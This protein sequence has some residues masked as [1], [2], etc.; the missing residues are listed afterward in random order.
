MN[1]KGSE[2]NSLGK[3]VIFIGLFFLGGIIGHFSLPEFPGRFFISGLVFAVAGMGFSSI[4][5]H[6]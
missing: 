1:K 3:A 5:F 6:F 2:F 4:V